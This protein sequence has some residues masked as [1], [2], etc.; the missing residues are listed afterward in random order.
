MLH[1][2]EFDE[3]RGECQALLRLVLT[4]FSSPGSMPSFPPLP[5]PPWLGLPGWD[6]SGEGWG[7]VVCF[8][9]YFILPMPPDIPLCV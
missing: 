7:G 4:S 5:Q 3:R 9:F 8:A 6:E 2:E 1:L